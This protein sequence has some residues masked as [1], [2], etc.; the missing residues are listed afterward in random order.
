MTNTQT[1]QILIQE[2]RVLA[3]NYDDTEMWLPGQIAEV[4][5]PVSY[6]VCI[7]KDGRIY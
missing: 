6:K 3:R 2:I 7:D 4:T 5:G 1:A